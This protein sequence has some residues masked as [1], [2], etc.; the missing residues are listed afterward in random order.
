MES[1][2]HMYLGSDMDARHPDGVGVRRNVWF[3]G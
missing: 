3:K 1:A 2:Q